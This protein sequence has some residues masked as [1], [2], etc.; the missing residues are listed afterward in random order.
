LD[1]P[2]DSIQPDEYSPAEQGPCGS[3]A[4]LAIGVKPIAP[5]L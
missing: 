3:V 1:T 4:H 5:V 2:P